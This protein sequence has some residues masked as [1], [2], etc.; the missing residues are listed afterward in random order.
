MATYWLAFLAL[1]RGPKMSTDTNPSGQ[2]AW[3][4][5][6]CVYLSIRFLAW[7]TVKNGL[8]FHGRR[9]PSE[10][11]CI[12]VSASCSSSSSPDVPVKM[13]GELHTRDVLNTSW[14]RSLEWNC[15]WM[16]FWQNANNFY[17][18]ISFSG[19]QSRQHRAENKTLWHKRLW[20]PSTMIVRRTKD[21]LFAQALVAQASLS[22]GHALCGHI[23]S[24]MLNVILQ[25]FLLL[26]FSGP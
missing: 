9:W 16:M 1:W 3:I 25:L 26:S 13:D 19:G 6:D 10:A 14:T 2:S 4:A 23:R 22:R 18:W 12:S 8:L 24:M 20:S 7:H 11:S 5:S 21:P 15:Q 17:G